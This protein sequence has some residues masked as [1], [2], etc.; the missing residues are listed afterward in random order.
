[1]SPEERE[2]ILRIVNLL[3]SRSYSAREL[4]REC[5]KDSKSNG[6]KGHSSVTVYKAI[7]YLEHYKVIQKSTTPSRGRR[8]RPPMVYSLRRQPRISKDKVVRFGEE[9]AEIMFK[10]STDLESA[11]NGYEANLGVLVNT[12]LKSAIVERLKALPLTSKREAE[13]LERKL[14]ESIDLDAAELGLFAKKYCGLIF[15]KFGTKHRKSSKS[16]GR[17]RK[18]TSVNSSTRN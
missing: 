1:M 16:G 11:L 12:L 6:F 10:H 14:E 15:E 8:G 5:E 3:G 2:C 17:A 9:F 4:I 13:A 7:D 18:G